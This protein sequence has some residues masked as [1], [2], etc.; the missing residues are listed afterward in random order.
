MTRPRTM[1]VVTQI[2]AKMLDVFAL[3][4]VGLCCSVTVYGQAPWRLMLAK[5]SFTIQINPLDANKL[6]VG[7]KEDELWRSNDGGLSWELWM[8]GEVQTGESISSLV[9]C[10]ADTNVL[11]EGGFSG[12]GLRRSTNGGHTSKRVLSATDG[13][14]SWFISE[15]VIE[16]PYNPS[17]LYAAR[18]SATSMVYRSTD[19]GATWKI[20][21]LVGGDSVYQLCTMAIRRDSS[22]ILFIGATPGVILRSDD[23]GLTWRRVPVNGS[24]LSLSASSEMPKIVF[25]PTNPLVGYAVSAFGNSAELG[26]AGGVLKTIDGGASWNRVGYADTSLWGVE[27]RANTTGMDEVYVGGSR[28]TRQLNIVKGDSIVGRSPNGGTTWERLGDIPW[29][30]DPTGKVF[31]N[32]WVLRYSAALNR[33]YMAAENGLYVMEVPT[34]VDVKPVASPGLC[35]NI[36]ADV[37]HVVNGAPSHAKAHWTLYNLQGA[38]VARGDIPQS[39]ELSLSLAPFPSGAYLLTWGN[40]VSIQTVNF[41]ITR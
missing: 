5:P 6:Y 16:D 3:V 18:A 8:Q 32:V 1:H 9:V 29:Q 23:S 10:A 2:K 25:S 30:P 38:E 20:H 22:N 4:I 33:L 17:T 40:D 31:A 24:K 36:A 34:D 37:L 11:I 12:D 19:V 14:R 41:A 27:V 39:N 28:L 15:A 35:A 13:G 21:S 26:E 7:S